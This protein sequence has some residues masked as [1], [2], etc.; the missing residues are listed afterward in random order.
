MARKKAL[1]EKKMLE[2]QRVFSI[3]YYL[4]SLI[5]VWFKMYY[6]I[7]LLNFVVIYKYV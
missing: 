1:R 3:M 4:Y 7:Y 5:S 2:T 6:M